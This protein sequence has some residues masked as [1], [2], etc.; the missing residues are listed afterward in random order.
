MNLDTEIDY[1]NEIK[2]TVG[3]VEYNTK[4]KFRDIYFLFVL[5]FTF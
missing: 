4:D 2:Y 1:N 3:Y 5:L